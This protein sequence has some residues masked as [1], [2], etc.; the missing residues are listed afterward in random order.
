MILF[1]M[2]SGTMVTSPV[3]VL[4]NYVFRFEMP[5]NTYGLGAIPIESGR[6]L[7][8]NLF[9]MW[10]K[11][12]LQSPF[13]EVC[14]QFFILH[15]NNTC[16]FLVHLKFIFTLRYFAGSGLRSLVLCSLTQMAEEVHGFVE[17]IDEAEE[18]RT[19]IFQTLVQNDHPSLFSGANE[20][21]LI[22]NGF[23]YGPA[24]FATAMS[25]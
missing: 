10:V 16:L 7:W 3:F 22:S 20:N 13:F 8:L 14:S 21:L 15:S 17:F 5:W 12:T 25:E 1:G 11:C 24:C 18:A 19:G 2:Q 23:L 9:P 4:P 6:V